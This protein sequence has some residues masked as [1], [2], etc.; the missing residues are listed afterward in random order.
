MDV[1]ALCVC[2]VPSDQKVPD[3]LELQLQM[4]LSHHIGARK[5]SVRTTNIL[6]HQVVSPVLGFILFSLKR[7]LAMHKGVMCLP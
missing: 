5:S 6:K 3:P 4:C 2:L 7:H 1:C